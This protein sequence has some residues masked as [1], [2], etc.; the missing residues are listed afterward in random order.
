MALRELNIPNAAHFEAELALQHEPKLVKQLVVRARLLRFALRGLNARQAAQLIGEPYQTVRAIYA[1]PT[2]KR[3]VQQ[4]INGAF[5]GVDSQF[6]AEQ[7]TVTDAIKDKAGAAFNYL[8]E[9]LEDPNA[10]PGYRMRAAQDILDRNEDT[11]AG[12]T[13]TK[14]IDPAQLALA[15]RTAQEMDDVIPIRKKA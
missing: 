1:D 9:L 11:Q 8:C 2:F 5:E 10:H 13:I 7:K 14:R 4:R 15:A 6:V 3:E 12:S